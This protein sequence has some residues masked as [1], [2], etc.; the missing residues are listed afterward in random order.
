MDVTVLGIIL[1][2]IS[3]II[4]IVAVFYSR[5]QTILS[6]KQLEVSERQNIESMNNLKEEVVRDIEK[7]S[8]HYRGSIEKSRQLQIFLARGDVI[9]TLLDDYDKAEK[10]DCIWAQCINCGEFG[11]ELY[12]KAIHGANRGVNYKFIFSTTSTSL[13]VLE[14]I[15]GSISTAKY[16]K[17]GDNTLRIQGLSNKSVVLAFQNQIGYIGIR[18]NDHSLAG[19]LQQWFDGRFNEID[20]RN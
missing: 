17:T 3:I 13:S 4:A 19:I 2:A 14:S 15:F 1:A 20:S 9:Q 10:G 12:K 11:E 7:S 16:V 8:L 18:I 6:K 5:N